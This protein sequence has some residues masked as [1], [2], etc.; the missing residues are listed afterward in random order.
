[1]REKKK[2]R[3]NAAS[4]DVPV[5]PDARW[6]ICPAMLPHLTQAGVLPWSVLPC[7]QYLTVVWCE[8]WAGM[9]QPARLGIFF[10]LLSAA[11]AQCLQITASIVGGGLG[12]GCYKALFQLAGKTKELPS[13]TKI[14]VFFFFVPSTI[15]SNVTRLE[16][17]IRTASGDSLV[18]LTSILPH[19]AHFASP[20]PVEFRRHHHGQR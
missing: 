3:E 11:A 1:M 6:V 15:V 20:S 14:A 2:M 9:L 10:F 7:L 5:M 4:I 16:R 8:P 19:S 18:I 12:N 17:C 13:L